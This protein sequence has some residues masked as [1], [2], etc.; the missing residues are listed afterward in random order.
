MSYNT[1]DTY[2][3]V[4]K[5]VFIIGHNTDEFVEYVKQHGA[6][7]IVV[8]DAK[9]TYTK[10]LV[11]YDPNYIPG[12]SHND[13]FDFGIIMKVKFHDSDTDLKNMIIN[14]LH[15]TCGTVIMTTPP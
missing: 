14:A 15:Q 6:K 2:D 13:T 9:H 3:F 8:N 11:K 1:F 5:T 7:R 4:N 12:L 10:N